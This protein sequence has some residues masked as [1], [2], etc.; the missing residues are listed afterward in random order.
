MGKM[1]LQRIT[2]CAADFFVTG[3]GYVR[4]SLNLKFIP[5][6]RADKIAYAGGL[7]LDLK[8]I[9]YDSEDIHGGGNSC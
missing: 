1:D 4:D 2:E 8:F 5:C 7:I 3:N 6:G 9:P